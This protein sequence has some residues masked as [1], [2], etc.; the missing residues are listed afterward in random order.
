MLI[1]TPVT[2]GVI[3]YINFYS[4][5][6]QDWENI[7][8]C[9]VLRG[10]IDQNT[11]FVNTSPVKIC[12]INVMFYIQNLPHVTLYIICEQALVLLA[13]STTLS[14]VSAAVP[15]VHQNQTINIMTST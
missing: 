9:T 1:V 4:A 6:S 14:I 5:I 2:H 3:A 15:N 10:N 7:D 12:V 11:I 8:R 13:V